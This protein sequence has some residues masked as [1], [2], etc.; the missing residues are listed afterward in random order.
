MRFLHCASGVSRSA[1]IVIAYLMREEGRSYRAA[2]ECVR[3]IRSVVQP[4]SGFVHQLEWYGRNGCPGNLCEQSSGKHYADLPMFRALLR[5][6]SAEQV[7]ALVI[8]AGVPDNN[9]EVCHNSKDRAALERAIDALDRLQ[10]ACPLNESARDEKRRQCRRI[11]A[12]LD[13]L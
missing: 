4:N 10:N 13:D 6:Y 9:L 1:S 12:A 8:A 7:T 11:H 5:M 2:L 3:G